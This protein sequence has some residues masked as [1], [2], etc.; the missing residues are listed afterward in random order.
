MHD[1]HDIVAIVARYAVQHPKSR[2]ALAC[3]KARATNHTITTPPL[4]SP[5]KQRL[6][7]KIFSVNSFEYV[8]SQPRT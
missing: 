1:I 8:G 6:K 4:R 5:W 7:K 3:S 2:D